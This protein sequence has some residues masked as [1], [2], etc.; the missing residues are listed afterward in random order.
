MTIGI[1]L[2]R[3]PY[4]D[5]QDFSPIHSS[6]T[7]VFTVISPGRDR[8]ALQLIKSPRLTNIAFQLVQED[9]N[10]EELADKALQMISLIV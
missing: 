9:A 5:A 2:K 1:L 8:E 10:G 4:K 3:I 6:E 7:G